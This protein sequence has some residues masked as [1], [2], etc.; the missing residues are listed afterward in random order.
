[1]ICYVVHK[2]VRVGRVE[3]QR[4]MLPV[5]HGRLEI[6]QLWM[7]KLTPFEAYDEFRSVVRAQNIDQTDF[8]APWN[9][10][11][12]EG[13]IEEEYMKAVAAKPDMP[14]LELYDEANLKMRVSSIG[15]TEFE[16]A[17]E[18]A[19]HVSVVSPDDDSLAAVRR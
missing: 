9:T 1:M 19:I 16:Q 2:K 12:E 7:G 13:A 15:I 10:A 4:A 6:A 17:G 11:A 5:G 14:P 8:G 3:L 18:I